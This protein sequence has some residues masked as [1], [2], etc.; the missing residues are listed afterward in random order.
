MDYLG[1]VLDRFQREACRSVD[2]GRSVIVAAPT[3]A[4]KT[5]IAE[6]A[7]ERCRQLD[8]RVVYTAPIKAL[9]NQKYR[10]FRERYADDVGIV[11]GDVVISPDAPILVMTTEI[12]RNT[13]FEDV[14]RLQDIEY[15]VF[16]EIHYINDIERG[17][18]WEECIIFAPQSIRFV[19]LSATIPN[20]DQFAAW[21]RSVREV[22]LDVVSETFR[23]VPLE[24]WVYMPSYGVGTLDDLRRMHHALEQRRQHGED[25][26]PPLDSAD[27]ELERASL[28]DHLRAHDRLPCLYFCFSRRG[29]EERA[30]YFRDG[31]SFLTRDDE[32]SIL[33]AYDHLCGVF[34]LTSDGRALDFRELVR[35]GVAYHHAGM[36]PTLKEVV[37]RLFTMGSIQLLFT[38]ETFAVGINMPAR[39]VVFDGLEKYDGVSFRYLKAREYQQMAGRAGRRGIDEK[40]FIYGT[41][42][43]AT[44]QMAQVEHILT[45]EPEPIE[46]QFNL[47]YSSILNLLEAHGDRVFDVCR[48]SFGNYQGSQLVHTLRGDIRTLE[49]DARRLPAPTCIHPGENAL[50]LLTGYKNL[51]LEVQMRLEALRPMRRSVKREYSGRKK[52]R[53][54]V[55]RLARLDR[56]ADAIRHELV[57]AKCHGCGQFR[58]CQQRFSALEKT[59]AK[60]SALHSRIEWAENYQREQLEARLKLL[61]HIGYVEGKSILPRGYVAKQ[62]YGYE[63]Q[64][65]ELVFQGLFER[66]DPDTINVLVVSMVFESKKD[67]WYRRLDDGRLK[68]I[69]RAAAERVEEVRAL[70]KFYAVETATPPLDTRLAAATLAWSKGCDFDAL[71]EYTTCPEGD[72]VRVFR[73][74]TDLLRQMRRALKE[75]PALPERLAEAMRRLN[76]DIVDAERQ[77][78]AELGATPPSGHLPKAVV[79]DRGGTP[80]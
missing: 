75:H 73:S 50:E 21:I 63:T 16:D 68:G 38:T 79:D 5:V 9:S 80:T 32:R 62:I 18:V 36:L 52:R 31:T 22:P 53:E 76:R 10:D 46:S 41:L 17:T 34:D 44:V 61:A 77:L 65:T 60:I 4:G 39:S 8:R 74:G 12:L 30:R 59:R 1:Y 7:I 72:L 11:T 28:V 40:G 26:A 56:E 66:A 15:V 57:A 24:H 70:E 45:G 78:R 20:L 27:W 3:G 51:S 19:C 58:V 13:I 25:A 71:R 37:E 69:L 23:P 29:C 43:P 48:K 6:Y 49:K 67:E 2:A 42:D 55:R 14:R 47:S 35:R 64:V 33:D 54:R